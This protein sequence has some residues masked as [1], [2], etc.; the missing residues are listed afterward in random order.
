MKKKKIEEKITDIFSGVFMGG[1]A[2][3]F[4]VSVISD[5]N[6]KNMLLPLINITILLVILI[7]AIILVNKYMGKSVSN[8][9]CAIIMAAFSA[10]F[11]NRFTN[12]YIEKKIIP[13]IID[14]YSECRYKWKSDDFIGIKNTCICSNGDKFDIKR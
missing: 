7:V 8:F 5:G 9:I 10:S 14:N 6:K 13:E 2:I 12:V 3:L 4:N 11:I 1:L